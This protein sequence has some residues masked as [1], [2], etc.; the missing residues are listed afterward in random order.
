MC[1][2]RKE[3]SVRLKIENFAKIK[4]AD[5]AI[6]GITVIAGENNTGKSTVGKI[7]FSL[8]KSLVGIEYTLEIQREKEIRHICQMLL[9]N[10]TI[11]ENPSQK[12]VFGSRRI[13][14]KIARE[15][16]RYKE[17]NENTKREEIEKIIID[18]VKQD[19][20]YSTGYEDDSNVAIIRLMIKNIEN[21]LKLTDN[22]VVL[23]IL[24][25][26]FEAVFHG[27]INSLQNKD[28]T[29]KLKL[30]IK[31]KA[32]GLLF[33]RDRCVDYTL[34]LH[35]LSNVI[36]IDN[37]FIIDKLSSDEVLDMMGQLLKESL[38]LGFHNDVMDN[39]FGSILAKEKLSEIY[40]ILGKVVNGKIQEKNEKFYFHAEDTDQPISIENLSTGLKSFV[41]LKMLIENGRLEEKD[42]LIL[43]EPEIHLHPKWQIVYAELI[44][45][46]QKYFDL[47]I[48]VTT[49][50]PYFL[51]AI[52][53]YSVKHGLKEKVNYYLSSIVEDGVEMK[54]VDVD[55]IYKK[56]ASPIQTLET[57]RYELNN[58]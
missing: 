18:I 22:T 53:L 48:I 46:L 43:D 20:L 32:I 56:M 21:I 47:S 40:K 29:A 3:Y 34:G 6:N 36:Y 11:D 12:I 17:K 57:L 16:R 58:Q 55:A 8:Y 26:Y 24:S 37:P 54:E 30:Q 5:I 39:I 15:I 7:I 44:V 41:V 4:N 10:Y 13:A 27:Q 50:S 19:E 52:D 35:L 1:G 9:K 28:S 31:G 23:E 49:H 14:S 42:V 2:C 25:R 51:D 38:I 33:Q 45:L